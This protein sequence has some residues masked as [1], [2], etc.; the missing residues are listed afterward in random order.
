M[1]RT[2]ISPEYDRKEVY[3]TYNMAE[4]SNFFGAKML[5]VEDSIYVGD[6]NVIYY[7]MP[8]G[9]QLD[10]SVESTLKSQIYSSSSD[11][12]GKHRLTMD[13]TQT[14][15]MKEN[16]TRWVLEI[17]LKGILTSYIYSQLKAWRTFEG[18]KSEMTVY[19]DV[20]KAMSTYIDLNVIDRY[21]PSK[22]DLYIQYKDLRNQ[23]L[24]KYKNYWLPGAAIDRNKTAKFQTETSPDLSYTKLTFSQEKPGSAY[25]FDYYFSVLFEKI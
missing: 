21:K 3:G 22:I 18:I 14:A 4:E 24:L 17:N 2:Y 7:Q 25:S 12:E 8:S 20:N 6:L 16:N 15:Y 13:D 1:R 11:K 9:E 10:L 23:N 5:E 19:N